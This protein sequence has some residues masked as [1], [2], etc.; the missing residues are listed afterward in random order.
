M[1][2]ITTIQLI[3]DLDG[4][5]LEDGVTLRW[6][7]DGKEY[8]IDTSPKNADAF[9][10]SMAKYVEASRKSGRAPSRASSS[11]TK[12]DRSKEQIQAIRDWANSNG[13][14]VSSRGRIPISVVDAF[15]AAH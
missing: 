11:A 9:R 10:K 5:V 3:D 12:S 4:N 14:E 1:A 2:R 8:E 6:G 7:L 15:D 13:Y